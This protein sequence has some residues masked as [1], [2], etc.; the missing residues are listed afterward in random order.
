M[1]MNSLEGWAK[2]RSLR[3]LCGSQLKQIVIRL[4]FCQIKVNRGQLLH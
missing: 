3:L 2:A 4:V 1:V